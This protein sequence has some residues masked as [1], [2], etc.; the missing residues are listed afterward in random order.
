[1]FDFWSANM[2]TYAQACHSAMSMNV[3]LASLLRGS[4]HRAL[5]SQVHRMELEEALS[6]DLQLPDTQILLICSRIYVRALI[7]LLSRR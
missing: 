2:Q 7:D 6:V 1:M 4:V 3:P 5:C